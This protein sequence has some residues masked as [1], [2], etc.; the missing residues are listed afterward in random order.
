M[1]TADLIFILIF[2]FIAIILA[3]PTGKYMSRVFTGQKTFMTPLMLPVEHFI[4]R[5]V[6]VDE[7]EEMNW[8]RYAYALI[9]FNII[10]ILFVFILQLLQ[11]FYL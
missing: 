9:I 3:V 1:A 2:L 8:K 11:D 5:V 4:Y 10:A 6:G 7:Q